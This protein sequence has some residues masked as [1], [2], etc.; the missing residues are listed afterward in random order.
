MPLLCKSVNNLF[1]GSVGGFGLNGPGYSFNNHSGITLV[2]STKKKDALSL[3]V[4]EIKVHEMLL[5]ISINT[6][7]QTTSKEMTFIFRKR[8]TERLVKKSY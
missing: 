7:R 5:S 4:A 3:A 1:L 2:R 8:T 6:H